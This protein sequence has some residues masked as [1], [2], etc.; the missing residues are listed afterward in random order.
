MNNRILKQIA[1]ID[2]FKGYWRGLNVLND[3]NLAKFRVLRACL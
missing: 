3:E 2:E 1:E